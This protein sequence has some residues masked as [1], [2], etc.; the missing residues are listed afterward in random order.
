MPSPPVI[1]FTEV[2]QN[3][4]NIYTEPKQ[5]QNGQGNPEEQKPGRRHTSP[6]LWSILQSYSK[7]DSVVKVPKPTHRP[8][9]QNAEPRN[10]PQTDGQLFF[11][12]GGKNV[13]WGKDSFFRSGAGKTGQLHVNQWNWNT[14]SYHAQKIN[15]KWLKDLNIRQDTIKLLEENIGKTFSDINLMDI[16]PRQQKWE[17]K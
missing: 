7:Q 5:A 13:K 12:W 6:R 2:E 14:P 15:S 9:E 4:P 10:N 16:L 3:H 8:L 11:N 17:Q 1:V